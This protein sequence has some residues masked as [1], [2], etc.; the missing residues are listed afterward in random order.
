MRKAI[1][2][3]TLLALLL[4]LGLMQTMTA[5]AN[6]TTVY[7]TITAQGREIDISCN[8]TGWNVGTVSANDN[9]TTS[10]TWARL[11]SSGTEDVD[12]TIGGRHME[13]AGGTDNWTLA[14][15]GAAAAD[16]FAMWAA[17]DGGNWTIVI[18]NVDE[19]LN[20]LVDELATGTQDFG[21]CFLAPTSSVGNDLMEMVGDGGTAA[22]NPRGLVLTGSID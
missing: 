10:K 18:K 12:V 19:T 17:L 4:S 8:Q 13:N 16:T 22:D 5:L 1:A 11:T 9:I 15:D 6:I 14:N 20:L 21:L 3:L 2:I 7:I